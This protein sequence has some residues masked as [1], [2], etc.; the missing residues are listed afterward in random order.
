MLISSEE[1]EKIVTTAILFAESQNH[2]GPEELKYAVKQIVLAK[3]GKLRGKEVSKT[4]VELFKSRHP[5]LILEAAKSKSR[6]KLSE[7]SVEAVRAWFLFVN[8]LYPESNDQW[9]K[10]PREEHKMCARLYNLNPKRIWNFDES[11]LS[12]SILPSSL[13]LSLSLSVSVI[14]CLPPLFFLFFF[15]LF[16]IVFSFLC[17]K[18]VIGSKVSE[19]GGYSRPVCTREEHMMA[20]VYYIRIILPYCH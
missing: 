20:V 17:M 15:F 11:M 1:E 13:S 4:F 18:P 8:S 5:D 14:A 3:G 10:N 9:T 7:C 12:K 2:W 6:V 19:R 16:N